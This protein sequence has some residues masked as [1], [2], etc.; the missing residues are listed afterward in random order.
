MRI[1]TQQEA[2]DTGYRAIT[3][4]IHPVEERG[5]LESMAASLRGTDSVWIRCGDL[6]EAARR[7]GSVHLKTR[8]PR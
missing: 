6:L 4:G 7:V 1:I 3:T 8:T 2:I 5:M